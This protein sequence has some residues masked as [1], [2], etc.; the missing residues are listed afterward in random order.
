MTMTAL[1]LPEGSGKRGRT[2]DELL[3]ATQALL[4]VKPAAALSIT[5][6]AA[7]AR[8]AQGTFY[9]YFDSID[10]LIDD[11]GRLLAVHLA[12]RLK[13]AVR[14]GANPV[15]VFATKTRQMLRIVSGSPGVGRLLFDCGLPLDRFLASLREDVHADIV[16]GVSAGAF[17]CSSADIAA[18]LVSGCVLGVALDLHRGRF[19]TSAIDAATRDILRLLGVAPAKA[20]HAATADTDMPAPLELPLTWLSLAS[21]SKKANR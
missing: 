21:D 15:D 2:L 12:L 13:L 20:M 18:S 3:S 16:K 4:L 1:K 9:N 10:R 6:V 11:L 19:D 7:K 8:M 14:D 5:D 17:R